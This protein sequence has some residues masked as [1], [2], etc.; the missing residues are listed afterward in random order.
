MTRRRRLYIRRT[1][2]R[3]SWAC[4][5]SFAE[6]SESSVSADPAPCRRPLPKVFQNLSFFWPRK[7][8]WKNTENELQREAL[9]HPKIYKIFKKSQKFP[10]RY[11]LGCSW[12]Q[13]LEEYQKT[14]FGDTLQPCFFAFGCRGV[15]KI[16]VAVDLRKGFQNTPKVIHFESHV[17]IL[18]AH[19]CTNVSLGAFKWDSENYNFCCYP[20]GSENTSKRPLKT[21]WVFW[22]FDLFLDT[23][24]PDS[25]RRPPGCPQTPKIVFCVRNHV[26]CGGEFWKRPF[27][28]RGAS[29]SKRQI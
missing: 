22:P 28:C 17:S 8:C 12:V 25:S 1:P 21:E 20:L 13:L 23:C 6:S 24:F 18:G 10:S 27:Y 15:A 11:S 29:K 16:T 7:K 3:G 4:W 5:T 9:G 26:F 14:W 19:M 2:F